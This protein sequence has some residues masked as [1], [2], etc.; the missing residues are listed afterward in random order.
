MLR[1]WKLATVIAVVISAG[2]TLG[3]VQAGGHGGHSGG[4][5]HGG[6]QHSSHSGGFNGG[7]NG[8]GSSGIKLMPRNTG[9]VGP[10]VP[11]VNISNGNSGGTTLKKVGG[12]SNSGVGIKIPGIGSVGSNSNGNGNKQIGNNQVLKAPLSGLGIKI[13]GLNGGNQGNG[14]GNG[15]GNGNGNGPGTGNGNGNGNGN[16]HHHHNCWPL[17]FTLPSCQPNYCPPPCPPIY[18]PQP[19]PVIVPVS[20]PIFVPVAVPVGDPLLNGAQPAGPLSLDTK[21]ALEETISTDVPPAAAKPADAKPAEVNP[22]DVASQDAAGKSAGPLPQIP[23]GA[24]LT[25]Q[26]KD[27]SEKEGQVLLQLGDIAMPA[28]IKEWK[29]DSVTCTLP[30]LGLAKASKASLHVLKA[31]GKVASVM[32]CELVT[33]LPTSV[34]A[35]PASTSSVDAAKYEQ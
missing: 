17:V 20:D 35:K 26:G 32:N 28:T 23:V 19:Y 7:F 27:L 21:K 15:P 25:L 3:S 12:T 2:G 22:A 14:N 34:A 8:G 5:S 11:R 10:L 33:T 16:S 29:N 31:D 30:V 1:N 24:T 13:G 18:Y 6:H 4:S 9:F